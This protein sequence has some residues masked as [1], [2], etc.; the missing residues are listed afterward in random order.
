MSDELVARGFGGR[1]RFNGRVV[2]IEPTSLDKLARGR[3][4]KQIPISAISAVQLKKPGLTN[5]FIQF[6]IAGGNE[7]QSRFGKSTHD[8]ASDENSVIYTALRAKEFNQLYKAIQQA[9]S[10]VGTTPTPEPA[11][12]H[13]PSASDDLSRLADLHEAGKLTDDEYAA[14][15]ARILGL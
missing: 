3:G 13:Q 2:T 7:K 8:A 9:M 10:N 15:K 12:A 11:P 4:S 14:A 6:T 1:I 5:G